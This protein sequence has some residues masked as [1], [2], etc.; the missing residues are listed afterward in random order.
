MSVCGVWGK[1]WDISGCRHGCYWGN[2]RSH[3]WWVI[4]IVINPPVVGVG[5]SWIYMSSKRC[6]VKQ[7]RHGI[8]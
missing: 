3:K 1:Q 6:T 2:D 7:Y 5:I 8:G 4:V